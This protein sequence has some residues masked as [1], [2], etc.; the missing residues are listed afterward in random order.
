[1]KETSDYKSCT[2]PWISY[3]FPDTESGEKS[4]G[5]S[6]MNRDSEYERLASENLATISSYGENLME[7][8]CRYACDGHDVG[9]VSVT[10]PRTWQPSVVMERTSWRLYVAM[11]AT[12]T[13]LEG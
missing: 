5:A 3:V 8:V 4:V 1:M 9:R 2:K 6:I 11:H 10:P 13:M 12:D 7:V